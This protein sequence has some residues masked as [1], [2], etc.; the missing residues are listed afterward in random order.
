MAR[1]WGVENS[2]LALQIHGGMGFIEETGIAQI[3][4]DSRI[5]PIYEGTNGVQAMDLVGR[6]LSMMGGMHWR[7]LLDEIAEFST[8]VTDHR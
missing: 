7:A 8:N 3:F 4:R 6:K 2:S 1:I 5:N